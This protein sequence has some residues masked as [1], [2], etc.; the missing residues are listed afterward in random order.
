FKN[1]LKFFVDY[2]SSEIVSAGD[3]VRVL[4]TKN[5]NNNI[6]DNVNTCLTYIE[7][8]PKNVTED[9]DGAIIAQLKADGY[10]AKLKSN[11]SKL[12]P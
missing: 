4:S 1:Q 5:I 6:V 8:F 3:N 12:I 2:Y 11:V 7:T 10:Y 9:P